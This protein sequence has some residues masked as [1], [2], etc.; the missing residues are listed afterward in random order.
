MNN[1]QEMPN[2]DLV[3]L[4]PD[5][6]SADDNINAAAVAIEEHL[7][8][9][10]NDIET[11]L[12]LLPNL[13]NLPERIVDMLAWQ[14]HLDFYDSTADVSVKRNRVRVAIK[15]HRL[16]GTR[17][18]VEIA[19]DIVFGEG[20]YTLLEWWQMSPAR[21]PFTFTVINSVPFTR[22][23]FAYALAM[24]RTLGNVRSWWIGIITWNQLDAIEHTWDALDSLTLQWDEMDSYYNYAA[25]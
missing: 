5:S 10:A 24:V 11:A 9:L 22:A 18:G 1:L 20:N 19:L 4:L 7:N 2:I 17:P 21:E 8:S 25:G 13:D 15:E 16:H 12:P 14:F 6:I 23:Q 3:G